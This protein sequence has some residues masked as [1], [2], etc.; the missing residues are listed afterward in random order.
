MNR[1]HR[2]NRKQWGV[3][4]LAAWSFALLLATAMTGCE[5]SGPREVASSGALPAVGALAPG[6]V[7]KITFVGASDLNQVQ[8]IRADGRLSLPMIGEVTAGGKRLGEFQAELSRLYKPQLQNSEVIVSVE[9]SAIPV[10]VSGAVNRPGRVLLERP[11]TAL[12]AIMEVGGF[13]SGLANPRKV[14]LIRVENGKHATHILDLSPSLKGRGADA[15][16]LRPY[17][18]IYVQESAF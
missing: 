9:S 10:Y 14:V 4:Y 2:V 7:L 15:F 12:E 13:T 16:W 18:V 17:D 5:T 3:R 1:K 6:D 8:K 11:M